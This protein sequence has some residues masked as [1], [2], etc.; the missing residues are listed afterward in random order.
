MTGLPMNRSGFR[1]FKR[2]NSLALVL[3]AL[4]STCY[5]ACLDDRD[6]NEGGFGPAG[7]GGTTAG[8]SATGG[9]PAAGA[10]T[11]GSL[12]AGEAGASEAGAGG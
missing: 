5:V 11:G 2:P 7:A 6:E 4:S 1:F 3:L 10:G 9:K 8:A 12:S